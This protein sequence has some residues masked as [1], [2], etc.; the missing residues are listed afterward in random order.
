MSMKGWCN[1][2]SRYWDPH[3]RRSS[4]HG[5]QGR[6]LCY[7]EINYCQYKNNRLS[8]TGSL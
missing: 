5:I 7:G 2:E 8:G 4:R 1:W 3:E 6:T